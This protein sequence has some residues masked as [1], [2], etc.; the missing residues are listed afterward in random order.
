MESKSF[1]AT[2][3]LKA[4]PSEAGQFVAT[5][6]TLNVIDKDHDVTI[7]GAFQ[8]GQ[9]VRISAWGHNWGALPV[10]NG[11]IHADQEKAW[12]DGQ[13]FLDTTAGKDTYLTVKNLGDLGEW[14]YGFEILKQSFGKFAGQDVRFLEGLNTFEVSPVMLGAGI[15]T[16][17]DAIKGAKVGRR[18]AA[19]DAERLQS[20]HDHTVELGAQCS[21]DEP[22]GRAD[23]PPPGKADDPPAGKAD[24]QAS[25]KVK[26]PS[27]FA[28]RIATELLANSG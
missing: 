11:T 4:D 5:F 9:A 10:G 24:D 16:G 18:N 19:K 21:E 1:R 23:D 26:A 28:L 20:I 6:A 2:I 3:Q 13:F 25:G 8:E 7:P 12:V 22:K 15:D 17:T 14:S 27:A